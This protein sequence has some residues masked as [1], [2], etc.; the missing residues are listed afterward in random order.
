MMSIKV[1]LEA[2]IPGTDFVV[3]LSDTGA[4][5]I[6]TNVNRDSESLSVRN[7]EEWDAIVATVMELKGRWS[8]AMS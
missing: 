3:S 5:R 8:K 7:P 6:H 2:S 1:T 4:V